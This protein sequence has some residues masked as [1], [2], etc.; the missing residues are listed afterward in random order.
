MVKNQ[1]MWREW[2]TKYQKDNPLDIMSNL[3]IMDALY[4]QW[5]ALMPQLPDIN[6]I[7]DLEVKLKIARA[8]SVSKAP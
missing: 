1:T 2:E 3:R 6:P 7:E 4:D 5:R 8:L